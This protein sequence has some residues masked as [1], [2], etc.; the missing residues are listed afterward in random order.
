MSDPTTT[1]PTA[2]PG[3]QPGDDATTAPDPVRGTAP[4]NQPYDEGDG[5]PNPPITANGMQSAQTGSAGG[6]GGAGL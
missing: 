1:P 2:L 3:E 5:L 6:S 4:Q